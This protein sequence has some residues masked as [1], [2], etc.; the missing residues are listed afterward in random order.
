MFQNVKELKIYIVI[1]N[2]TYSSTFKNVC[3]YGIYN[4]V[5][6][7]P[8]LEFSHIISPFSINMYV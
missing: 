3:F 1:I 8:H 2:P 5:K 6:F 4:Y 7:C